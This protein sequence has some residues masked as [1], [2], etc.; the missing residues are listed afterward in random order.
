[1]ERP[2]YPFKTI[3][4]TQ[5]DHEG[6]HKGCWAVDEAGND[7]GIDS[8]YA[9]FTGIIKKIYTS[10]ANE[11]WL[12]SKNK[13]EYPDGTIDYMTILLC[14]DNDVSDLWVGK[15]IKQ[16]QR[17]YEEG[18]KGNATGN[19]VHMECGK[20]KF[21]GTGWHKDSAGYWSINNGKLITEC[22]FIDDSYNLINTAGYLFK[23]KTK[24]LG[25]PVAR[26][27][28]VNQIRIFD[29]AVIVRARKT[30]NGEILGYMNTGIYNSLETKDVD[31]YTWHR[32]EKDLWFA[33][34]PDWAE[35]LHH[36]EEPKKEEVKEES[37]ATKEPTNDAIKEDNVAIK[38]LQEEIKKLNAE[39]L[40]LKKQVAE[41]PELIFESPKLDFYAIKL[42]EKQ[43]L[44]ID[45]IV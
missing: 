42:Q 15:E 39:I 33:Y 16:G 12:E 26:N 20:G 19:H 35:Y 22:L 17:F 30:A 3:R 32:V 41:K 38:K 13:V 21:T 27:E 1:M 31:G 9:P 40:E 45:K 6:T 11:V 10:D 37:T 5:K 23:Q 43:K 28:K 7:T 34:S 24:K 44:Y 36:K 29:D 2:M 8:A 25:T 18:T 4:I 14:H